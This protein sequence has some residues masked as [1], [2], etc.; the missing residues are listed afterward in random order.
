MNVFLRHVKTRLYYSG[1]H[2]WTDDVQQAV[3]FETTDNAFH[4]A[5]DEKLAHVE[6]VTRQENN[7]GEE[8][9][10]PVVAW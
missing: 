1:W 9:V 10:L 2:S 4:K 6:V 5:H 3:N 7:P 8:T